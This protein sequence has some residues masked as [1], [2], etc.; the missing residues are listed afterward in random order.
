M[1]DARRNLVIGAAFAATLAALGCGQAMLQSKA[2]GA[3]RMVEAPRFEVDP[4]WPKPLPN[5][6][7]LGMTIGVWVDDQDNIWIIHR[8]AATLNENER[9]LD[10]KTGECCT[11]APPVLV[12]DQAGNLIR[13]WGGPGPGY[14]WPQSNHGVHVDYKGNVWIGGNGDKDAHLLKFTKEG[15]FLMQVGKM[16]TLKGSNDPENFGRVAK[17]WVDPKTNEAYVADGYRNKR[18]AVLDADT[19]RMKRYWGAYGNRP[20]DT[21]PGKYNPDA[22]PGKQFRNPVHCVERSNDGLVYVCDR[23]AD[24]VQVFNPDG[25][26]VKEAFFAKNTLASGSTWDIAFSKDA[27]QKYI[28]MADGTNEKVRIVLRDT[29]Q[30]IYNFGDGGRQ[31]GQFFGVHSI[32]TDSK[33]NVYTTETYEGKRVQKFVYNGIGTV[34]AGENGVNWPRS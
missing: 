22:P 26:F 1:K 9:A 18:V 2:D 27:A 3:G 29:L 33:G 12:F 34:Q 23:Q 32:A 11:A 7:L 17:I 5:H 10:L 31:P 25:T 30:E 28:F 16:G 24:R 13:S 20:D 6:W 19:G 8:G 14:E 21:D 15:K 4:L